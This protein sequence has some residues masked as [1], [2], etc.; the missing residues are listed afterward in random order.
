MSRMVPS[1][2]NGISWRLFGTIKFE[3]NIH[4][5]SNDIIKAFLFQPNS[6]IKL[7]AIQ[8]A[9]FRHHFFS[10]FRFVLIYVFVL[11]FTLIP[12]GIY[13]LLAW[14]IM[15]FSHEKVVATQFK[16]GRWF[17]APTHDK[18]S[19]FREIWNDLCYMQLNWE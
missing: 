8:M 11:R 18:W 9:P 7:K 15:H 3:Y 1:L 12:Q 4:L 14:K 13:I 19:P 10:I 16:A 17:Y 5:H 6:S 2:R